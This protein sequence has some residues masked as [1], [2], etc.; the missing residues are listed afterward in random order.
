MAKLSL[1]DVV[2]AD[3][4]M[5]L[6]GFITVKV[7]K[8]IPPNLDPNPSFY[9]FW[10]NCY[11]HIPPV[12]IIPGLQKAMMKKESVLYSD[13]PN[14]EAIGI[15][16]EDKVS[17]LSNF[18]RSIFAIVKINSSTH[19]ALREC[20]FTVVNRLPDDWFESE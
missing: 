1:A 16:V 4:R 18:A 8:S 2:E 9:S 5:T 7:V 17:W 19:E 3:V 11:L 12:L 14:V 13:R 20:L 10:L 6:A 15:E